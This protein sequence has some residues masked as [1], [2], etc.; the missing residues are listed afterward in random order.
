MRAD[1]RPQPPR[2]ALSAATTGAALAVTEV[3]ATVSLAALVFAGPLS[4][5]LQRTAAGFVVASGIVALIVGW[6]SR[7]RTSLSG[8]QD[9]GAIVLLATVSTIAAPEVADPVATMLAVLA[10]TALGFGLASIVVAR[11]QLSSVVRFL[12]TT[13]IMGFIAGTGWLLLRGGLEVLVDRSIGWGDVA[14]VVADDAGRW[15]PGLALGIAVVI[16][17]GWSRLPSYTIGLLLAGSTALFF[18]VAAAT[19]SI[20]GVADAGWLVGPFTGM[21]GWRPITPDDL[22]AA[23]WPTVAGLA[24]PIG[25]IVFV[26]MIGHLLNLKGIQATSGQRVAFGHEMTSA[27]VANV[28]AAPVG[29]LI[30]FHSLGDTTLAARVGIRGR[31]VPMAIGAVSIVIGAFAGELVG[32]IPRFVLGGMLIGLGLLL[33]SGWMLE[34]RRQR[35]GETVVSV[36]ILSVVIWAG[37][38]AGVGV[39]IVAA[40]LI[41]LVRYSRIDPVRLERTGATYPSTVDRTPAERRQ[42]DDRPDAVRVYQVQ[43]YL[44]FGSIELLH[45]RVDDVLGAEGLRCVIIDFRHVT[46]IDLS[47]I[48]VLRRLRTTATETGVLLMWSDVEPRIARQLGLH[49]TADD[50]SAHNFVDLDHAIERAENTVLAWVEPMADGGDALDISDALRSRLRPMTFADGQRI[51]SFGDSSRRLYLIESGRCSVSLPSDDGDLL[52]LREFGAGT[53]FGEFGFQTGQPR[54]A[55]IHAVGPVEVLTLDR[56]DYEA[57]HGDDPALALELSDLMLNVNVQRVVD[58]TRR[59]NRELD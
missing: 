18:A 28:I 20:D 13:V 48:D 42:L 51:E 55:D 4:A 17:T 6:R 45:D 8:A 12:P 9:L 53:V 11:L 2:P 57:M 43:G 52:R 26:S 5:G 59:L 1:E 54:T 30:G 39:G 46:G 35:N 41:F 21:D 27:G 15:L 3:A 29:G 19:S 47:A 16:A 10:V 14:S 25:A 40:S 24:V 49:G 44:F 33:I 32:Y 56:D 7:L 31:T 22:R 23:D 36:I 38:L 50:P 37:M 34:L 58:L